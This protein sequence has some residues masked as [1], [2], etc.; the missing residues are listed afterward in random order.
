[1]EIA[2]ALALFWMGYRVKYVKDT[3]RSY[4][5]VVFGY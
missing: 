5:A 4:Q 1:M 3:T 2:Q